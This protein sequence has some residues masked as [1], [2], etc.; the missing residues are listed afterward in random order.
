MADWNHVLF[1]KHPKYEAW[2]HEVIFLDNNAPP[3]RSIAT[4]QLVESY[5]WEHLAHTA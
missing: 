4:P 2:Q 1:K 5:N 3:Q